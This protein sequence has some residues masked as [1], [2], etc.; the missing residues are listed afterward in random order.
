MVREIPVIAR[1]VCRSENTGEQYPVAVELGGHRIEIS[2]LL[3]D[4][5]V[6]ASV[7]GDRT[8]RRIVV[9]LADGCVLR[10]GRCLPDGEWRVFRPSD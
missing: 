7:A 3:S 10:L 6:G 8:E 5:V 9:R 4:A 2:E 1:V